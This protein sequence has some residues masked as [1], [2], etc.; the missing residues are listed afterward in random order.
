[1]PID[2]ASTVWPGVEFLEVLA[3]LP[4]DHVWDVV[5]VQRHDRDSRGY[6]HVVRRVVQLVHVGNQLI[7]V[8]GITYVIVLVTKAV[9]AE[10]EL[11]SAEVAPTIKQPLR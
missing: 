6:H 10:M 9:H 4:L 2:H 7:S 8:A 11:D 5:D 1:M 3:Q